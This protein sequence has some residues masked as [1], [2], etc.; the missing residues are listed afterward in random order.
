MESERDSK[1]RLNCKEATEAI[2]N[3]TSPVKQNTK[4]HECISNSN[5]DNSPVL[6]NDEESNQ[7]F[8]NNC[9]Q[10]TS[11]TSTLMKSW[12][13]GIRNSFSIY[14]LLKTWNCEMPKMQKEHSQGRIENW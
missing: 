7:E 14:R 13:G 12:I 9:F 10:K 5:K 11:D 6:N 2:H 3:T 4:Y 8:V 1:K